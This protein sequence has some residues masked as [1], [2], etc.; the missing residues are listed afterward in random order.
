[1][2]GKFGRCGKWLCVGASRSVSPLRFAHLVVSGRSMNI[3]PHRPTA[4]QSIRG[5]TPPVATFRL[6]QIVWAHAPAAT[7]QSIIATR[8][9]SLARLLIFQQVFFCGATRKPACAPSPADIRT[10]SSQRPPRRRML[11]YPSSASCFP[12]TRACAAPTSW[13][14]PSPLA[15]SPARRLPRGP[16][17]GQP[18]LWP[19]AQRSSALGG[20]AS[21]NRPAVRFGQEPDGSPWEYGGRGRA[22]CL[23]TR[24]DS[25]AF[26][27]PA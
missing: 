27:F 5:C 17:S 3:A 24:A 10:G 23:S 4:E 11:P 8:Q 14:R 1:M 16:R 15:T 7:L 22:N 20:S 13:R 25:R 12:P 26:G 6:P 9:S 18:E 21:E 2:E 19:L